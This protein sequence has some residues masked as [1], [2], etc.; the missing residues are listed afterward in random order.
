MRWQIAQFVFCDQQQTLT[1]TNECVQLEPMMVALLSYFCQNTDLIVSKDLLIEQVWLGRI[2][3]D[4]AVSKLITKLR[5]VF[6]DDAR[7]PKFI[8][9]FPKKGYKFIAN[10]K[11][12]NEA[13]LQAVPPV[14]TKTQIHE[15]SI[16]IVQEETNAE[17]LSKVTFAEPNP[18]KTKDRRTTYITALV[19]IILIISFYNLWQQGQKSPTVSTHTKV[20]TTDAGDE[21]YPDFSPDGT[22]VAYM[23]VKNDQMHLIIKNVVDEAMIEISHGE[24]IGVGPA[25]WSSDGKLIVYLAATP[26]QCQYYIRTVNGLE[27]GEPQLI[28]NCPAGSYGKIAFSHDN[29]RLIYAENS[30]GNT[31]YSL[32]ELNLTNDQIKRLNQPERFLGGNF[33]FDL[34]PTENK[35]LISSPD[36]QQWEGFYSLDLET[37]ELTLLFKQNAYICCGIWSHSGARVV[38]MGEHPAHQLLSYDLTGHDKQV[39]H[40]GSRQ[41]RSPRR[42]VNETDYL[43]SSGK[44]NYN[45]HLIDLSTKKERVIVND[46][47]DERLAVFAHH[48]NQIA[49]IGL[50]S[51]N[52]EVWLTDSESKQRKKLT[53]FNDS[54]HYVDLLWSPD[55]N[56]LVAL[57]LNEI[58]LINSSTGLFERLKIPQA[59]I[60]GVSF[61][62]AE[63]ISYSMKVN[64]QWQVYYYQLNSGE[65]L[66]EDK[67]WQFIQYQITADNNLWLDQENKLFSGELP[68]AVISQK[69]SAK[70]LINGRQ[71]NLA[72]RGPLWF[73]F[74]RNIQGQIQGY[75]EITN[76]L[77]TLTLTETAHFDITNNELLFGDIEQLNSNIYQTQALPSN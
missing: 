11:P 27:L 36:K 57:T 56:Y 61:K 77:T 42:H 41:I 37:D 59:Q 40:S 68:I 43:F 31:P 72:K 15:K 35:L 32:F 46:S 73:W 12:I 49:Y 4:N 7:Q 34:H 24:N 22:R 60:Q 6:N 71:F 48:N 45:V 21:V 53:Q 9:T 28:H 14:E 39:V 47:V 76:V 55:G 13:D 23:S 10:V 38:L 19:I 30:G 1:S 5:K 75:S 17:V 62:S 51:G 8:A 65:V 64:A 26:Q 69:I 50:A 52:E 54:R 74:E 16:S 25:S 29:N 2:V 67:K 66:A 20:L 70:N 18:T 3:S 58:H 63:T 44:D 33:Q